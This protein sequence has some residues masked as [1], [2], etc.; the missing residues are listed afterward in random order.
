VELKEPVSLTAIRPDHAPSLTEKQKPPKAIAA[1]KPMPPPMPAEGESRK[2]EKNVQT[3]EGK[4]TGPRDRETAPP[5]PPQ[6]SLRIHESTF[7]SSYSKAYALQQS[8]QLAQAAALYKEILQEDPNNAYVLNNLGVIHQ[9]QGDLRQAVA[10]YE[11]AHEV[12]PKFTQ[13]LNNL[14]V[15][16]Y[17]LGEYDQSQ[18]WL[19]KSLQIQPDNGA[20]LQNL[21][22][23]YKK[24]GYKEEAKQLLKKAIQNDPQ[25][26]E[27][28]FNLARL[29]E[30][31]GNNNQAV[32]NYQQ[33]LKVRGVMNDKLSQ[34]VIRQIEKLSAEQAVGK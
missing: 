17:R 20:V 30:E 33:F 19:E 5:P 18:Q 21:A 13:A 11:K 3:T 7:I 16:F 34:E 31:T 22:L 29:E 9:Q 2:T 14:G 24:K 28:Y 26:P 6:E 25:V 4:K 1:A 23:V 27:L 32:K 8:G 15:V 10:Y 12:N